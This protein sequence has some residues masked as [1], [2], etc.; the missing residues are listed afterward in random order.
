MRLI[1]DGFEEN[2][3]ENLTVAGLLEHLG[4]PDKDLVFEL[5]HRFVYQKDYA[6][7]RLKDGD[8]IELIHA[9]FGG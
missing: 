1:I 8:K 3:P 2:C 7:T 6:T 5:N 4:E 9:A